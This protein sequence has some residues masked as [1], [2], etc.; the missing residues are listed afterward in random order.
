L[1]G[2]GGN[3]LRG[4]LTGPEFRVTYTA[5]YSTTQD[6]VMYG[7]LQSISIQ[8][9]A[10]PPTDL[11]GLLEVEALCNSLIDQPFSARVRADGNQLMLKNVK[12]AGLDRKDDDSNLELSTV[13]NTVVVGAYT[14]RV[15]ATPAQLVPA[16]PLPAPRLGANPNYP[17]FYPT[18]RAAPP[19]TLPTPQATGYR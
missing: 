7:V 15:S 14:K 13:M 9:G 4:E 12:F 3:L 5:E 10:T 2:I 19:T 18:Y 8:S 6:S 1:S 11:D 16:Q 17:P